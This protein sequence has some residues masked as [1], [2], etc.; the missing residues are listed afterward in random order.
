MLTVTDVMFRLEIAVGRES[1]EKLHQICRL[2]LRF[3][4]VELAWLLRSGI[5]I[6]LAFDGRKSVMEGN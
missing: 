4:L 6:V 3:W 5:A 1:C 2:R